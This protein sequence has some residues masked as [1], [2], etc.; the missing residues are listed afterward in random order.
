MFD[1]PEIGDSEGGLNTMK[2]TV[3]ELEEKIAKDCVPVHT[4]YH[5][6]RILF[7]VRIRVEVRISFRYRVL[8][9]VRVK[10]VVFRVSS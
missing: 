5:Y 3:E 1:L 8:V 9:K 4:I 10:Y 2:I 6:C 7:A